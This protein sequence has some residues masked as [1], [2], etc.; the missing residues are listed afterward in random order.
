MTSGGGSLKIGGNGNEKI[1][2]GLPL[3][4]LLEH[5]LDLFV[6]VPMCDFAICLFSFIFFISLSYFPSSR[7]PQS[8]KVKLSATC[9]DN[10]RTVLSTFRQNRNVLVMFHYSVA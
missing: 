6:L 4:Y 2:L 7:Y 9:D 1:G 8:E 10:T 5:L 3:G